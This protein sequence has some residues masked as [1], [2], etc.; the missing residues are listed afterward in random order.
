MKHSYLILPIVSLWLVS[1]A[2]SDVEKAF[3]G[4][5]EY[6]K[7]TK[8]ITEY[9][10]SCHT[11]K[12]FDPIDHTEKITVEYS[13]EP[14]VSATDCRTCHSVRKNFWNDLIRTTHNPSGGETED[15]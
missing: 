14:Y 15:K 13:D 7:E 12:A 6:Q 4:K 8:I 11:H 10:Q 5:Y 2:T 3:T 1:C 9:C